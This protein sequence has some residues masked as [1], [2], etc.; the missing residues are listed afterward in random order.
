MQCFT[1]MSM[2]SNSSYWTDTKIVLHLFEEYSGIRIQEYRTART[3]EQEQL[4]LFSLPF[5]ST[6]LPWGTCKDKVC[7]PPCF[8]AHS[9]VLLFLRRFS[10]S[11]TC[12][13]GIR[14][15][16]SLWVM[17]WKVQEKN[18]LYRKDGGKVDGLNY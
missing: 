10:F 17:L 5:W 1:L 8:D 15:P 7:T 11:L 18:I 2:L 4:P 13:P 6:G 9:F 12:N 16:C 14:L 3:L